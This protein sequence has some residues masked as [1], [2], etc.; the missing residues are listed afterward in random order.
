[1]EHCTIVETPMDPNSKLEPQ[2]PNEPKSNID[3]YRSIV[4]TL[5]YLSILT[6]PDITYAVNQAA[7]FSGDPSE[8]HFKL[9]KR[10]MRY[11]KGMY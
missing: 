6:H 4:G 8:E 3:T 11:L 5:M 7:R 2:K 1:M 10:I 9:L